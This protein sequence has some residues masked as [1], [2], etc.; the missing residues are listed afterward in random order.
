MNGFGRT[1]PRSDLLVMLK[2]DPLSY[3]R[4]RRMADGGYFFARVTPSSLQD[5]YFAVVSLN[6]L[7]I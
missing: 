5:T 4:Q 1:S 7:G 3:I 6:L 2:N